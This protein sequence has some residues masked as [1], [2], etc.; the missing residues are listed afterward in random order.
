[1]RW[2][3]CAGL[4]LAGCF[5]PPAPLAEVHTRLTSASPAA[6]SIHGGQGVTVTY[7]GKEIPKGE[8]KPDEEKLL[9]PETDQ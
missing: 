8:Q 4:V 5:N 3:V 7:E 9:P 2:A 6:V 1:M